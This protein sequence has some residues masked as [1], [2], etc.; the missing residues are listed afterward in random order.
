MKEIC[1]EYELVKENKRFWSNEIVEFKV[2]CK[3]LSKWK[4]VENNC[5]IGIEI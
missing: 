4:V 2:D 5:G 3:W 1:V